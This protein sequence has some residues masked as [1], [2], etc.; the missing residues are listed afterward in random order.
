MAKISVIMTIYNVENYL[1]ESLKSLRNQ[2]YQDFEIIIINDGSKDKTVQIVEEFIKINR[3]LS[4]SF[5]NFQDN[6][7]IPIRANFAIDNAIGEYIA[8]QD[9]DDISLPHR[10]AAEVDLLDKRKD[11]FAVGTNAITI[12]KDGN[13]I[14]DMV[15]PQLHKDIVKKVKSFTNSI[16]NPSAMFRRKDFYEIGKYTLDKEIYLVQDYELWT[17]AILKGYLLY[18]IQQQLVKY[19]VNPIGNTKRCQAC[20]VKAHRLVWEQFMR[21]SR[22]TKRNV[23]ITKG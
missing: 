9:G 1:K 2:T 12:D 20:M 19:R 8:I 7:K 3:D 4:I 14:G 21:E 18:N 11:I 17:R 5:F 22:L 15:R 16:I 23:I 13:V 6:K 10:F